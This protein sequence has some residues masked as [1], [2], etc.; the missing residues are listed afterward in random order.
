MVAIGIDLGTTYS[1]VGVLTHGKVEIIANSEGN[2]TTPSIVAFDGDE[3]YVGDAARSQM[4]SNPSK[5]IYCVKR[6]MGRKY[7]DCDVQKDIKTWPFEVINVEGNPKIQIESKQYSPEEVS[8]AILTK[9]KESAAAYLGKPI[10][11]AVITVPAYFNDAQRQA[12]KDA[13]QIAGL[14]VLRIIN[15]PTAAAIAYGLDGHKD[16][17][18]VI[19]FDLGGGTF[20]VSVLTI[21]DGVFE[22]LATGGNCH[23]GGEDFDT[24]LVN[25]CVAEFKRKNKIDLSVN[26]RAIRRIKTACEMAKRSLSSVAQ[27]TIEID[28]ITSGVDLNIQITR[29]R[30]EELNNELFNSTIEVVS[31]VL[32]DAK[33]D[34]KN[35]HQI[36]LVGGSTRIPRIQKMLSDFFGGRELNKTINPDEAVA[37]G[38]AVQAA[39]L[40]GAPLDLV[41]LDVNPLSIGIETAG[42][43]MTALIPR[44]STIP[45]TKSQ[46]FS[47]YSDNQSIVSIQIFEGERQFTR[48]NNLIGKFNLSNIAPAPRG[49]PQIEVSCDLDANG[50]LTVN[51]KDK[52]SGSENKI[53]ITNDSGRLTKEQIDKMI[54][55]SEKFAAQDAQKIAQLNARNQLEAT[56]NGLSEDDPERARIL[57]WLSEN[58][59]A[60]I[61]EILRQNQRQGGPK[62]DEV[63]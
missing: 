18:N 41:L 15:E 63:D 6:L 43:V 48:D 32:V 47:T 24:N 12:T 5:S 11:G 33:M 52:K 10:T 56:A 19:I 2:R 35:I 20:D 27:T 57:T 29:A 39:N 55:D 62:I 23:L 14:N 42:G 59:D 1:C 4:S 31:K 37:F 34:K 16:E 25:H 51:A 21:A 60:S 53:V 9:M 54:A 58:P 13:G 50:I 40:T 38:A 49:V 26:K 61:D 44:N 17:Q 22:V 8:A 28:S 7:N 45:T 36:V 46:T 3:R 30:F